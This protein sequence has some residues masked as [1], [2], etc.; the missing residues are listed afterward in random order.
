VLVARRGGEV[1]AIGEV[2]SHL[3]G[4]LAEGQLDGDVVQCPWH[5]SRFCVRDGAVVDGPA[6]HPQPQFEARMAGGRVQV[7]AIRQ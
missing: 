1:F 6:T 7:R 5:A 2:C 4:P 3:G